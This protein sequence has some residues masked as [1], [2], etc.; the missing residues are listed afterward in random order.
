MLRLFNMFTVLLFVALASCATTNENKR[1]EGVVIERNKESR[2]AWADAP[3]DQL[4]VHTTET[5]FHYALLKERDL[6]ISVKQAQTN[7]IDASYKFWYPGFEQRLEDVP[8]IKGLRTSP[9]TAKDM[10]QILNIVAHRIHG[11]VAQIEDIY[12]EKV[13]IDNFNVVPQLQGVT[14]YFDVHVLV[15][16]MPVD[17]E[18]LKL[19]LGSAMQSSQYAEMKQV[20]KSLAPTVKD[21]KSKK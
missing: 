16:L 19:T 7:A 10:E 15:Q 8:Q 11:D 2:P 14:E 13:R 5:R 6:P 4:L 12:Y 9:R 18:K 1:P 20:G 3:E 21:K 17:G